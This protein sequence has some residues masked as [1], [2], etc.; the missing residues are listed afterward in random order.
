MG[1]AATFAVAFVVRRFAETLSHSRSAS[2]IR[3]V[4]FTVSYVVWAA[5]LAAGIVGLFRF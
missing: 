4:A 3:R 5:V 1:L 2:R